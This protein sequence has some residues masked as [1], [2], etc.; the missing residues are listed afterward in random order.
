MLFQIL[1]ANYIYDK[2]GYPLVQLFGCKESGKSIICRVAGF[3]PYFYADVKEG[4]FS[5]AENDITEMGLVASEIERF[6][7]IGYQKNPS[8]MLKVTSKDPKE[9]RTFRERVLSLPSIDAVYETDILFRN[10]FMIDQGMGGMRWVQ[11]P[12]DEDVLED[13]EPIT[14][15]LDSITPVQD[16]NVKIAPLKYLAFDIEC[17][18]PNG[19]MPRPETSPV[20]LISLAFEPAYKGVDDLV[21]VGRE[22][23]CDR[24][25]VI[26]CRNEK[27][28]LTKFISII[29]DFDPD[30]V[31][32]YNSNDFDFPYL[33]ERAKKLKVDLTVGRDKSSWYVKKIGNQTNV[34]I[35]GRVVMDL[36]PQIRSAFSLKRYTLKNASSE[37]IGMEKY[38]VAPKEMER[39]WRSSG[40]EFARLVSYSRRDAVLALKLLLELRLLD[41]H[42]ALAQASG[43][44]LQDVI[45]GGQ[46]GMVENLLLR[47]FMERDRVVPPRP[48]SELSHFRHSQHDELK[49]GAV[50]TPEKGL[51]E[52]VIIL[53]YKS[54]YPTIMMAHNLCYSTVL[55]AADALKRNDESG[56]ALKDGSEDH[57]RF[58]GIDV[59]KSPSGGVFVQP[60]VAPGIVPGILRDLLDQRTDTRELMKHADPEE[61]RVL[62]A[63]QYALK[64]LLNSFYGYSGYARARLYSLTVANAVTSFGRENIQNTRALIEEIGSVYIVDQTDSETDETGSSPVK[65]ALLPHEILD[66]DSA[67]RFDLKVVYGDT[68]SVFISVCP[69]KPERGKGFTSVDE[70]ISEKTVAH[71]ELVTLAEAEI[72]GKK[73]AETITSKLPEPMELVFEGFARRGL[74]IAKKRYAL[75]VFEPTGQDWSDKIKVRGMETVRRDWCELTSKTLN[76]CL[77]LVLKEGKVNEAVQYVRSTIKSIQDMD[78]QKDR[79][80][81]DDLTLTRRYT[82]SPSSYKSKQPHIQLVRKMQ[83][84]GGHVPVIGDRVPFVI[85]SGKGLFVDKAEDPE[86]AVGHDLSLDTDYYIEKQILPPVLRILDAF[87]IRKEELTH[88]MR[89]RHLLEFKPEDREKVHTQSSLLDF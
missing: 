78:I 1:D 12:G 42:I 48:G 62:D 24:P 21:L 52:N 58:D 68:D 35:T 17:I 51:L 13:T 76:R 31:L 65:V 10:R 6:R 4:A 72:I 30:V 27:D 70:S 2:N 40:D 75:W 34:A 41:K 38:D 43:A 22:T 50:L 79:E 16:T 25:D 67:R 47:K 57:L 63:K 87:G 55:K 60:D 37:L 69:Y 89:Q 39:F 28:M 85:V 44:L 26:V 86:Y 71:E 64:I 80:M 46:T 15:D 8:K 77:E 74:F 18:S 3:K 20:I 53:D 36:L 54:L 33:T 32:G 23:I 56:Q 7:P 14:F 9:V 5:E 45:N 81:V 61:F 88:G 11:I 19:E 29:N 59:I 73:I 66:T 82:K 84:R 83:K 49:G